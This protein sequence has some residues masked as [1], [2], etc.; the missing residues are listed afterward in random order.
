MTKKIGIE[1]TLIIAYNKERFINNYETKSVL[2]YLDER[3]TGDAD[4]KPTERS[5]IEKGG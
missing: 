3:F 4:D 5:R 1:T 2:K